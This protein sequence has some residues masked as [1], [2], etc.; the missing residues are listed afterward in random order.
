MA[1]NKPTEIQRTNLG[2]DE[3]ELMSTFQTVT[4]SQ[5]D[6]SDEESSASFVTVEEKDTGFSSKRNVE[7]IERKGEEPTNKNQISD[8]DNR[9]YMDLIIKQLT[10]VIREFEEHEFQNVVHVLVED[11]SAEIDSAIDSMIRLL[12]ISWDI[13]N[14]ASQQLVLYNK[15]KKKC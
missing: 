1:R 10:T 7:S 2:K 5:K 3:E 6:V 12:K 15:L 14:I 11:G 4:N 13:N 9:F 8:K